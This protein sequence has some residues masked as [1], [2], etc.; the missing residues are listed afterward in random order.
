MSLPCPEPVVQ[1]LQLTCEKLE[2]LE[3]RIGR[4]AR[5]A[6]GIAVP[7]TVV[8][9]GAAISLYAQSERENVRLVA[10]MAVADMREES[11]K[12]VAQ[13][14]REVQGTLATTV[15]RMDS[16]EE[17]AKDFRETI[18]ENNAILRDLSNRIGGGR[19][20]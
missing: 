8:I 3:A 17:N 12:A 18:R 2:K 11:A 14:Q 6:I 4:T 19:L 9:L 16:V 15:A 10:H 1:S 13:R 7:V 5:W 20:K